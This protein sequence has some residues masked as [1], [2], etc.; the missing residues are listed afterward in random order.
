MYRAS[1]LLAIRAG[2]PLDDG[3][4]LA[5]LI[6]EHTIDA[7]EGSILI[8][9]ED[10][11]GLIRTPRISDAASVVSSHPPVR[12]AMVRLQRA[13]GARRDTVAEGRD[14]ST[15]V[16]PRADLKVY[17]TA[18]IVQ[19]ALRRLGDVEGLPVAES[20]PRMVADLMRRDRRDRERADSPL[21]RAPEAWLIDTT[22][23]TVSGQVERVVGLY[24]K[25]RSVGR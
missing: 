18:D 2:L 3:G 25:E 21:R 9:G 20:L 23:M 6:S 15:V 16:F 13:F 1:A 22:G 11:S 12:R 17:V 24:R 7:D 8:D 10:V 19:R 4:R 5:D 14:M